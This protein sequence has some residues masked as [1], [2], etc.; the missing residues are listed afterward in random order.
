V[1]V[2]HRTDTG[3]TRTEHD[4]TRTVGTTVAGIEVA[5]VS[6]DGRDD[7]VATIGAAAP[8]GRLNVFRQT[9]TGTLAAPVVYATGGTPGPVEA[10]DVDGDGRLDVATL[11]GDGTASVLFQSPEGTLGPSVVSSLPA[12]SPRH[13]QSL[14]MSDVDGDTR[15][16][17]VVADPASGLVVLRQATG[18]SVPGEAATVRDVAPADFAT[19]APLTTAAR[20]TFQRPLDAASVTT[21][22]VRLMHG[23]SGKTVATTPTYDATTRTVTLTPAAPLQDNTPYRIVAAGLRDES[24]T[25]L[26]EGFTTTFQTVNQAPPALASLSLVGGIGTVDVSWPAPPIT[27]L[28]QV[29]VRMAAGTMTPPASPTAGTAVYTGI[30]TTV[31]VTGLAAGTTYA[32]AAWVRDRTGALSP[33]RTGVLIGTTLTAAVSPTTVAKGK[34][35]TVTGQLRRASTTTGIV[36]EPVRLDYRRKG[37]TEWIPLTTLTTDAAGRVTFAHTPAWTVEYRWRYRGS[38]TYV[39]VGGATLAVTVR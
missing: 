37:T 4:T 25:D 26:T 5:D 24:G 8:N 39:G 6:G 1:R 9:D 20:V 21:D 28:D 18:P 2:Y 34:A 35:V 17:L 36:G 13:V 16:D 14:A 11:H 15:T 27:D 38:T 22:T 7:V 19:G 32:F 31:F 3:F 23:R 33:V 10:A 29:V 12:A 30:G